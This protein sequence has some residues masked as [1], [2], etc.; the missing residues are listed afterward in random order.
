[1][2]YLHKLLPIVFLPVG[3]TT[4]LIVSG[5]LWHRRGLCWLGVAVL[6]IGSMPVVGNTAI[7][8]AEDWQV[9]Q[10]VEDAPAAAAIVVLSGGR[11]QPPGDP[12]VNEWT[13]AIDRF[14]VGVELYLAG[15]AP[16]L[17][18]TDPW[19]PWRPTA[20]QEGAV[21]ADIAVAQGVPRTDIEVTAKASNTEEEAEAVAR[22]LAQLSSLE[23]DKPLL[24]VTSAYHMRR[25]QLIF[26]QAGLQVTPFPVDFQVQEGKIF[27]LLDLLPNAGSLVQTE[28][29]LRE[30]YGML[31]YALF[32][33]G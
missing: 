32:K 8:A 1:M 31:Y 26:M 9:R 15:K 19:L 18:L 2:L 6:W 30:L 11:M 25:A 22:L 7:R 33:R 21:L 24:L 29:A 20:I 16:L 28:T 10:Q 4:L 5:L 23:H 14:E 27:T 13:E 3:I 12:E 17:I